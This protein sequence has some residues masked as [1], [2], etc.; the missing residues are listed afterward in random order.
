MKMHECMFR[1]IYTYIQ[2]SGGNAN[3][4]T[5]FLFLFFLRRGLPESFQAVHLLPVHISF[6]Q[7]PSPPCY[8]FFLQNRSSSIIGHNSTGGGGKDR[9]LSS[10]EQSEKEKHG[11]SESGGDLFS[12][13]CM[14][15]ARGF[16]CWAW[17]AGL[18][19]ASLS[20]Y[21]PIYSHSLFF[22]SLKTSRVGWEGGPAGN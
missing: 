15:N 13:P 3:R 8:P 4:Q 10:G 5:T 16:V 17:L 1:L 21:Q 2:A 19:L 6:N 20:L 14:G 11:E 18:N 7:H 22:G 9:S 12:K